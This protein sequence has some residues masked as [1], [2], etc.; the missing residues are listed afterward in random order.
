LSAA[1][2]AGDGLVWLYGERGRWWPEAGEEALWK[3]KD[4]YPHWETQLPG[5]SAVLRQVVR[6]ARQDQ[7][8]KSK[9]PNEERSASKKPTVVAEKIQPVKAP[10][11]EQG[12][13]E[14]TALDIQPIWETDRGDDSGE[15]VLADEQVTVTGA[16]D[17]SGIAILDAQPD[18][19][20]M[21]QV[22]VV[23][24]GRGLTKMLIRWKTTDGQW[25][26]TKKYDVIAY[27]PDGNPLTPRTITAVVR[28]PPRTHQMV[29]VCNASRQLT[30]DDAALF[31][32]LLVGLVDE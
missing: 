31:G 12:Q 10:T 2:A 27:P 16:R 32:N 23:Q 1:I 13:V 26:A 30:Q 21:V 18:R 15:I 11:A 6:E 17:A 5:I 14:A 20:Y 24:Q 9:S 4:S 29:V 3:G 22:Q 7:A 25:V 28:S 8:A 19:R